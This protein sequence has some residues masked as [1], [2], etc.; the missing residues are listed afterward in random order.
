MTK[1]T[2]EFREPQTP[3]PNGEGKGAAEAR[4]KRE[5]LWK[6]FSDRKNFLHAMLKRSKKW[7]R[8]AATD[9]A[10]ARALKEYPPIPEDQLPPIEAVKAKPVWLPP[11]CEVDEV[12]LGLPSTRTQ[13]QLRDAYMWVFDHPAMHREGIGPHAKRY[14]V[15]GDVAGCPTKGAWNLLLHSMNDP[16]KFFKA[17]TDKFLKLTDAGKT[18]ESAD[19]GVQDDGLDDLDALLEQARAG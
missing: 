15:T 12:L 4:L 3:M 2:V 9:E 11:V 13:V 10:W 5:G 7:T 18:D 17:V 19:Q 6:K 1:A 16:E 14:A 8:A